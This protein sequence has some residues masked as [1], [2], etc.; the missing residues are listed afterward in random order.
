MTRQHRSPADKNRRNIHTGC[1]H[2]KS[3]NVLITVR[4]HNKSVKLMCHSQCFCRIRDQISCHKRI[5]HPNMSHG[6]SVTD[7][8]RRNHDRCSSCHSNSHFNSLCNLIQVHMPRHDLIIR[9]HN[10]DQR[11]V[12]FFLCHSQRIE[13]GTMRRLLH[14]LCYSITSHLLSSSFLF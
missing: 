7:C 3:R 6:N 8:N 13:Q 2:Q 10:S 5:F 11:P 12:Q 9:T 14:P 1:C 4:Y